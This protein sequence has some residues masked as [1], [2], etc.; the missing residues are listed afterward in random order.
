[1]SPLPTAG[2]QCFAQI[3]HVAIL[4]GSTGGLD[5]NALFVILKAAFALFR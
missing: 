5:A 3:H 4:V 2:R 1:M